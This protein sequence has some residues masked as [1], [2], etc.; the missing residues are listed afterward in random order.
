M[1]WDDLRV[2]RAVYQTGSYAAAARRLRVNETTVPRR[3]AR[4][5]RDLGVSLFDAIDGRRR[6]TAACERII[7]LSEP[8]A[9]QT[10]KIASMATAPDRP[11]ERRRIAATDSV[12]TY[13]IAPYIAGFLN[14]NR[15]LAIEFLASTANVDFSRWEADIAIR[16]GRPERGD[17]V[18]SKLM[19]FDLFFVEPADVTPDECQ[20]CAYPDELEGT[21]ESQFLAR[22]GV[23]KRARLYCKNL[24]VNKQLIE[25]GCCAGVLPGYMCSDLVNDERFR[26][27]KLPETRSAWLLIQRHLRDEPTTRAIVDWLRR[28][29]RQAGVSPVQLHD[30]RAGGPA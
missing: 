8:I 18:V 2:V 22:R 27:E 7:E 13:L 5:E 16:L 24:M 21:P 4:L 9:S 14:Q 30:K 11:V 19:E 17:F 20:V 23:S 28:C 12:S 10:A 25:S 3:L 6:A 1:H 29:A 26:F 15:G